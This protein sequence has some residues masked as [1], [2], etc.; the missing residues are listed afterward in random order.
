MEE[1]AEN[2]QEE[3]SCESGDADDK[4]QNR[5]KQKKKAHQNSCKKPSKHLQSQEMTGETSQ[6]PGYN[7]QAN[8]S[9]MASRLRFLLFN[10]LMSDVT[11]VVG[12]QK[13]KIPAHKFILSIS[14]SVFEAMFYSLLANR[15]KEIELPDVEP[16]AFK[17]L[18]RF[19]YLDQASVGPENVM[20]TL[21]TAKKYSIQNL[22]K[23]CVEFL[24]CNLCGENAFLLLSQAR[25]FDESK[26]I[27]NCL[28][29]IDKKTQDSLN[30]EGFLEID[31]D[32]LQF[33]LE[34]DTLRIREVRLYE[35]VIK[36]A[37]AQCIRKGLEGNN[38][39]RREVLKDTINLIRY[40]LMSIEEFAAGPAQS[41][42]LTDSQIVRLFLYY[43][44]NP[45][46]MTE[47]SDTPRCCMTGRECIISRFLEVDSRWGYN[48]TSDRIR[49]QV[50]RRIFLAGLGLYGS[51][52]GSQEYDA[53]IQIVHTHSTNVVG[54]NKTK[55]S[56]DG[57]N[58]PFRV[59][60]KEPV[61]I[62]PNTSYIAIATLKGNDSY[63]GTK[64]LKKICLQ[65]SKGER[66][67]FQFSYAAGNNNGTSVE[68]GQIPEFIFYI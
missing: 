35:A 20:T 5:A 32:T 68:D 9:T 39:N 25:L 26:L 65:C 7:W 4:P 64:G 21:Y 62:I 3:N 1:L 14:S 66:V 29:V 11:F 41:G 58:Q 13:E 53:T 38:E 52:H 34:R 6:S 10:P 31:Y 63:Y 36:W 49:F 30:S 22:E 55:F 46:P 51:I 61:E 57:S 28:D 15:S 16:A 37:D 48:G 60:F 47:F 45:K 12:A 2:S 24:E 17:N 33:V 67:T 18:L 50:D 23:H 54:F 40:P 42:L 56:C 27:L 43:T 44:L 19:I 8:F 59:M